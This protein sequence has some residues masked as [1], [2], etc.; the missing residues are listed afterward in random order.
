MRG[1]AA[2]RTGVAPGG[3]LAPGWVKNELWRKARAVPSLDLRFAENKSLVDATTGAS[4]VTFTRASSGTFVG[5]DGVL[6]TA[7]TNEPRF[8]HN[9]TTGGSLGLLVEEQ[10]TN[11]VTNNTMVGAVAGT[12]G[13]NPTGW[14]FATAQSNGLTISIVGTGVENGIN[15][16]DYRFNGTTIASPNPCAFGFTNA[17]AATSQTWATSLYWKLASGT[18]TGIINWQ[19]GIIENTAVGVFVTG[20]FYAQ[21]T[22]TS[23]AL[24][25][26]RPTATRTLSG[27][28]TV[29][30]VSHTMNITVSGN[31][32]IDFTIRI[33]LPQLEQGAFATSPILTS[34]AAATRSADVASITGTAF[35]SWYRQDEGTVF[36][37][38]AVAQPA[39]GGNQ[40]IFRANDN[41]FNNN[42]T[43]NIQGSGFAS[44][45]TAAGGVF[46]GAAASALALSANTAAK[47]AGAYAVNNLG[48]S[49]NGATAVTDTSATM[50]TAL[51]RLHIGSDHIAA[52]RVKA[53]TIRRLTYWPTR[54]A[55]STLQSITQ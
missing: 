6:R 14:V 18:T 8:D 32:A 27:G 43:L 35:S 22:P 5:S 23:A 17:A 54:L 52:N 4:L 51:N 49:L 13:T 15:Y 45:A 29:G 46:D 21:A 55:N 40:F 31:T 48:V 10:R 24:I 11:S 28:V 44:I 26:Q 16:S 19:L 38:C 30:Q 41:S 2:F 37:E 33:G 7:A 9:P 34:T 47:F 20:A 25:T 42:T 1:S 53:G 3:A 39:S 12:P 36:A 50:P